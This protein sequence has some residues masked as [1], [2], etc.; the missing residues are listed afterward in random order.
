MQRPELLAAQPRARRP[1]RPPR[2]PAPDRGAP[3]R[4]APRPRPSSASSTARGGL[5]AA[6]LAGRSRAR[7]L[8]KPQ[9]SS[10]AA[11][12]ALVVREP[13][14]RRGSRR[15][16]RERQ[17]ARRLA[18]GRAPA[19]PRSRSPAVGTATP[20]RSLTAGSS[21]LLPPLRP[22]RRPLTSR[23]C[24]TPGAARTEADMADLATGA[25]WRRAS[26]AEQ[27]LAL[28]RAIEKKLLWLSSWTIHNANHLR[29]S[30]DKLKVGGHQA[31]C[32]SVASIMT[33]LYLRRAAPGRP[34]RGQAACE[35]DLPRRHAPARPRAD[36]A[37]A[38]LPGAGRGAVLSLAHQGQVRRRLLD[39]LGRPGRGDDAVR[40]ADPG[41]RAPARAGPGATSRPAG[42]SR[43]SATP[44][45]TRATST[46][47][48]SRA[49]ST[50]SAI[51]G[52]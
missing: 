46:R 42:W 16:D 52:G 51:S 5:A 25:C 9:A 29:P 36:R 12:H 2:A 27:R 43:S 10:S 44:S 45:S 14:Q 39:R 11:L 38:A 30:R 4:P 32:A 24:Y 26:A 35:P 13:L 31:S 40:L 22:L 47:P 19:R 37:A 7:Q 23:A 18:H 17:V 20:T 50:T 33:A 8:G 49:G 41:L 6:D 48:C 15:L 1:R 34:R 3:R 28:L 21:P